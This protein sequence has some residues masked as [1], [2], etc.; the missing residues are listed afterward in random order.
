MVDQGSTR[1][2]IRGVQ[3]HHCPAGSQVAIEA[4]CDVDVEHGGG[5]TPYPF[6]LSRTDGFRKKII[7]FMRT[8]D[9]AFENATVFVVVW[10]QEILNVE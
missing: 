2:G 5:A 1:D 6:H 10:S 4:L 8:F 7:T 9:F 3:R